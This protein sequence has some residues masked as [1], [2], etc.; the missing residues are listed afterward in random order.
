MS[1]SLY[2]SRHEA[3][4]RSSLASAAATADVSATVD[5]IV[6]V[7]ADAKVSL[8]GLVNVDITADIDAIVALNV[9][10]IVVRLNASLHLSPR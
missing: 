5:A 4:R 2:S 1:N 8:L 10:L 9:N 6:K 7:F 3:D